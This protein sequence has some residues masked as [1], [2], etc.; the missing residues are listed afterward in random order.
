MAW[1]TRGLRGNRLEEML[2]L[3]NDMYVAKGLGV[4]QKIPTPITPIEIDNKTRLI[5]KA[6]FEKKSTVDYMGVIQGVAVCFDAK[7]TSL[8]NLPFK[9]IHE[10]QI[11]FM[12]EFDKQ[13]GI[14]F[15]IVHFILYDEYFFLPFTDFVNNYKNSTR[16]SMK[17]EEF[18]KKYIVKSK[19]GAYLH[20][21]EALSLYTSL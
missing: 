17:Y 19:D 14:A 9:N 3:T 1:N 10:H 11:R 12:E 21:L 8:K 13:D 16:K 2:N 6:Y 7:E 20:Y 15:F 5:T 4:V 18:D